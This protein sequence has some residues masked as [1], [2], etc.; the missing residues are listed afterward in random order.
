MKFN[1]TSCE[2]GPNFKMTDGFIA[3]KSLIY[4]KNKKLGYS[5]KVNSFFKEKFPNHF[6]P[7][8]F[9]RSSRTGL[10]LLLKSLELPTNSKVM[11]QAFSCVV[12][13][14]A[15]LQA[16]LI[17]VIVD[18]NAEHF[19]LD[20]NTILNS[21]NEEVKVLIIQHTFGIATDWTDVIKFCKDKN[22]ILIEDCAHSLGAEVIV[23]GNMVEVGNLGQASFFSFGRDKIVSCTNGGLALIHKNY[24]EWQARMEKNYSEI[25]QASLIESLR[26]LAY[27]CSMAFVL[28][29]YYGL[30]G[31]PLFKILA[32][33]QIIGDVYTKEEKKGTSKLINAE[34]MRLNLFPIL[35]FQLTQL[36]NFNKHRLE[37]AKIYSEKLNITYSK[38]SIFLRFPV[39]VDSSKYY[40]IVTHLKKQQII[41]GQWYLSPFIPVQSNSASFGYNKTNCPVVENLIQNRVLNLPTNINTSTQTARIIAKI[42]SEFDKA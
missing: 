11:L 24:P 21:W 37:I 41:L 6:Q 36:K 7:E 35:Y 39:K 23:D 20:L 17:P 26:S 12:V 42:I 19:N 13:P 9:T 1:L 29:P 33:T 14:N 10:Y 32:L 8:F 27:I 4:S 5:K 3:L 18:I 15:V 25:K 40:K 38:G 30:V 2:I 16:G 28:R 31:K 22:I 34:K